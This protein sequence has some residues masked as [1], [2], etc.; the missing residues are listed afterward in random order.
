MTI[1]LVIGGA[2]FIGSH[3][4]KQ[5]AANGFRPVV[6]D[7]LSRGHEWAVKWGP[8]EKGSVLDESFLDEVFRKWKPAGVTHFAALAYVGESFK[9]PLAYYRNNVIGTINLL[10]AMSRHG[11]GRL[12][13]SSSCATYGVPTAS[14]IVETTDQ[15]P[16]NP[17]GSS[18][19]VAEMAIRQIAPATGLR[20]ILLRYFNAAGSDADGEIG[21]VHS[22]ETHLI[23]LVL[24]AATGQIPEIQIFGE[25]YPT[26]DGT[27]IRDYIHVTD[28]AEAH[29]LAMNYLDDGGPSDVFN[30]GIGRGYSVREVIDVAQRVTGKTVP[31]TVAARR[32]GDPAELISDPSKANRRLGWHPERAS[33]EMQITDAWR[34][35]TIKGTKN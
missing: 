8:L 32:P 25:D 18:K 29:V 19:L 11:C 10:S 23:P 12:V 15:R 9:E 17:Y 24:Q 2:G 5:L 13:F 4:S 35:L 7:D 6:V 34:W 21:E 3:A 20:Y 30:L 26:P 14:P 28:L 27:C 16:I 31:L 33:L 1:V 22:P